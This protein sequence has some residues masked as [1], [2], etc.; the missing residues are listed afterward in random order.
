MKNPNDF[1]LQDVYSYGTSADLRNYYN[2]WAHEYDDFVANTGYILPSKLADFIAENVNENDKFTVLDIGSGTGLLG[3]QIKKVLPHLIVDGVDISHSMN[4]LSRSKNCYRSLIT[5]DATHEVFCKD[6]SYD[7]IVSTGT[8]TPGHLNC[9]HLIVLARCLKPNGAAFVSVNKDEYIDGDYEAT[10]NRAA[11][12]GIIGRF[13]YREVEAW[14]N[15][16]YSKK[17]MLLFFVKL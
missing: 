7:L 6:E 8:F 17:A 1:G 16:N 10:L 9:G 12:A 14:N 5:A 13:A 3:E 15:E 4:A 11:D 2:D